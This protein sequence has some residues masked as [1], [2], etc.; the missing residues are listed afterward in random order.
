[1]DIIGNVLKNGY[2]LLA[3]GVNVSGHLDKDCHM[4]N[5]LVQV[6]LPLGS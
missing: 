2:H 1:M 5:V 6:T 4:G 3:P